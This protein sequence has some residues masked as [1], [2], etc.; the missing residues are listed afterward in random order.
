MNIYIVASLTLGRPILLIVAEDEQDARTL[1]VNFTNDPTFGV[2]SLSYVNH[3]G[4]TDLSKP[5][6]VYL[7][8]K[9]S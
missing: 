2:K 8:E 9:T 3:F 7:Q 5:R 6:G 4:V 1:A